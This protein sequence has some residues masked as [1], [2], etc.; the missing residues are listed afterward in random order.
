MSENITIAIDVFSEDESIIDDRIFEDFV[1]SN[2]N[3]IAH[4]NV[5]FN[6]P[7][8]TKIIKR[9]GVIDEDGI[10]K[11][12][13]NSTVEYISDIAFTKLRHIINDAL[14][15]LDERGA[16]ILSDIDIHNAI[17]KN[18]VYTIRTD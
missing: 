13:S 4:A 3:A 14:V 17:G 8:I 16:K 1:E 12:I 5:R 18:V 6:I 7:S 11:N 9:S 15:T 2:V 10:P